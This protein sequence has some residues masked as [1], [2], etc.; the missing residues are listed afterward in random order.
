MAM[1][2]INFKFPCFVNFPHQIL[3]F[4][5]KFQLHTTPQTFISAHLPFTL[6]VNPQLIVKLN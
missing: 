1:N 4:S 2:S 6:S 3:M 5:I